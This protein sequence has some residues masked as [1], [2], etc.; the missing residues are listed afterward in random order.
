E[1]AVYFK[2]TGI[3]CT[4]EGSTVGACGYGKIE[5]LC[6]GSDIIIIGIVVGNLSPS[7]VGI[8]VFKRID[9]RKYCGDIYT[10]I[11]AAANIGRAQEVGPAGIKLGHDNIGA[12]VERSIKCTG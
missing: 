4:A 2:N 5:R 11:P 10:I 9:G 1:A 8:I 12:P 7:I 3:L 6:A